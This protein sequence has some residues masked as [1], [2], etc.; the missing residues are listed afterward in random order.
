MTYQKSNKKLEAE[1]VAEYED[2]L[3]VL[4][5]KCLEKA[6]LPI[7][8]GLNKDGVFV[9]LYP[10]PVVNSTCKYI[11]KVVYKPYKSYLLPAPLLER[12]AILEDEKE[13]ADSKPK[14]TKKTV[15]D[16]PSLE[17]VK[18]WV[19]LKDQGMT[20]SK[21]AKQYNVKLNAVGYQIRKYKARQ[22]N[23]MDKYSE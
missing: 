8:R 12:L 2:R 13:L 6:Q 16:R 10:H 23:K 15:E 21:I 18:E 14:K 22:S 20:L 11:E 7:K 5:Y 17:T 9:D 19:E 3:D 1:R 4:L